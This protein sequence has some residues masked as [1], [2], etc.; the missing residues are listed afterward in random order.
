MWFLSR[1]YGNTE[2]AV[3][4]NEFSISPHEH[5]FDG[6]CGAAVVCGG[7]ALSIRLKL[8]RVCWLCCTYGC[9]HLHWKLVPTELLRSSNP[10]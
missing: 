9:S 8:A 6:F 4:P 2:L 5:M 7:G 10:L 3:L 1:K